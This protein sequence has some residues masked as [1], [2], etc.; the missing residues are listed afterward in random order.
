SRNPDVFANGTGGVLMRQRVEVGPP[1]SAFVVGE[2]VRDGKNDIWVCTG[3]SPVQ[4]RRVATVDDLTATNAQV[5]SVAAQATALSAQVGAIAHPASFV[6]ITPT[7][8]YDSRLPTQPPGNT[9]GTIE[10]GQN[11]VVSI[12]NGIDLDSGAVSVANVVPAGATGI[13]C[14]FTVAGPQGGGFLAMTPGDASALSAST[15]NWTAGTANL[16]NAATVKLDSNRQV[17][18]FAGGGAST[19]FIIDIAGYYI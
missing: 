5:A 11:R 2:I 7:R 9:G 18:V 1:T 13:V 19:D 3:T 16:A 17:K 10:T 12:A 4:W 8:V 15:I 14:N 6:L